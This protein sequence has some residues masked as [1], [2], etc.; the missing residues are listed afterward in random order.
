M[1]GRYGLSENV[2]NPSQ[3]PCGRSGRRLRIL[4]ERDRAAG[5]RRRP[6]F[7]FALALLL[8]LAA[9]ATRAVIFY[10]TADPSFNTTAPTGSLAG[11]GWQWVGVWGGYE[12]T[13]I[14]ANYFLTARHVGGTVGDTFVYNGVTYTTTAFYDDTVSDLRICQVSGT[15]P[16]WAPLYRGSSEVGRNLV[17]IGSGL[18]R[19][20]AILVNGTTVGWMWGTGSGVPRWGQNTIVDVVNG[21]SY[22]GALLYALF[23]ASSNPNQCTL[24]NGDSSSPIFINDGTGWTLAGIGAAVDG[25][26]N[27][28]STGSGFDAAL[29]DARGLYVLDGSTWELVTG[30]NAVPSGFYA[31]QVSVRA[32]WIDSIVPPIPTADDTPALPGLFLATLGISVVLI[33]AYFAHRNAMGG[34][35]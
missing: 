10:G 15:F 35:R 4:T 30:P 18:S 17:V 3:A 27:T 5:A 1:A 23:S 28:T 12:G 21:G 29:F 25:P 14:G 33:G 2:H 6:P 26:F 19:G 11:S 8:V 20:A 24:A 22:W 32:A 34:E 9:P 13:P 7:A 16:A 31:S